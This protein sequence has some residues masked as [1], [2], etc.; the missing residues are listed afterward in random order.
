MTL[1]G[2]S[3]IVLNVE[4]MEKISILNDPSTNN[5]VNRGKLWLWKCMVVVWSSGIGGM[6]MNVLSADHF[7]FQRAKAIVNNVIFGK[8]TLEL[9]GHVL[10]TSHTC[11]NVMDVFLI[12]MLL[13]ESTVILAL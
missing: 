5:A 7:T 9:F 2:V 4:P 10:I 13:R 1:P 3:N 11:G 6:I 12:V 8:L